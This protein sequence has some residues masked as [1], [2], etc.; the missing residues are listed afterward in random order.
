VPQWDFNWLLGLFTGLLLAAVCPLV[1]TWY[2]TSLFALPQQVGL[3]PL[4]SQGED[5]TQLIWLCTFA[6]IVLIPGLPHARRRFVRRRVALAGHLDAMSCA[7]PPAAPPDVPR[8]RE[9]PCVLIWRWPPR[10]RE[11]PAVRCQP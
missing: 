11:V 3:P 5:D 7:R 4:D 9:L 2:L 1:A 8:P 6:A 10:S